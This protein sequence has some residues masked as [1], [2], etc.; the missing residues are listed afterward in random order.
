MGD[1]NAILRMEDR[2]EGN[3]LSMNEVVEFQTYIDNYGLIELPK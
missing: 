3:P 1:F 2:V